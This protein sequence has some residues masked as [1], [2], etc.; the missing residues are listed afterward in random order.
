MQVKYRKM[1]L[2]SAWA[3]WKVSGDQGSQSTFRLARLIHAG[4]AAGMKRR[5][6]GLRHAEAAEVAQA[7]RSIALAGRFRGT[8][9]PTRATQS[10][11]LA[12]GPRRINALCGTRRGQLIHGS[13]YNSGTLAQVIHGTRQRAVN[14]PG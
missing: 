1:G 7:G 13:F 14:K 11:A 4:F 12:V 8:A 6:P 2:S 3:R 9:P 5:P 10:V